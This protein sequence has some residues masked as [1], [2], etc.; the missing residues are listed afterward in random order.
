MQDFYEAP[1]RKF[2]AGLA[3]AK[4]DYIKIKNKARLYQNQEQSQ[5]ISKSRAKARL[6]QNQEQKPD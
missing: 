3:K 2:M 5:I 1:K 6:N 4:P